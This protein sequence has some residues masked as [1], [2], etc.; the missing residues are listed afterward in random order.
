MFQELTL[1][2]TSLYGIM[3]VKTFLN[4]NYQYTEFTQ[5]KGR[6]NG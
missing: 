4:L 3:I 2:Q 6:A 5:G 1:T